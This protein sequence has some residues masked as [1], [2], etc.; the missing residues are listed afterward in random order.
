MTMI[1]CKEVFKKETGENWFDYELIEDGDHIKLIKIPSEYYIY[2][3]EDNAEQYLM[4]RS[5]FESRR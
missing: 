1:N 5:D 2:W 4:I 3:L